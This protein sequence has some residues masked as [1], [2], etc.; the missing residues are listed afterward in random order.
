MAYHLEN[1][2]WDVSWSLLCFP[3][4]GRSRLLHFC[5][6]HPAH[7]NCHISILGLAFF[8]VVVVVDTCP[9]FRNT[10]QQIWFAFKALSKRFRIGSCLCSQP[11]ILVSAMEHW[12]PSTV[13]STDPRSSFSLYQSL[14]REKSYFFS[15]RLWEGKS[16]P[17]EFEL[18]HPN[19]PANE[20]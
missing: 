19:K 6:P 1:S 14:R 13:P 8:F 16:R 17:H 10:F 20:E 5:V 11:L 18:P 3:T 2:Y 15:F 12:I 9:I 7:I 4:R